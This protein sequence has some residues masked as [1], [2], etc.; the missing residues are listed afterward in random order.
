[1]NSSLHA[2]ESLTSRIKIIA[3]AIAILTLC[4]LAVWVGLEMVLRLTSGHS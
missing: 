2:E 3:L 1:M 4:G